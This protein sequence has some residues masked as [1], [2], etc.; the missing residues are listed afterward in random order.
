[1]RR[2]E[3]YIYQ[4]PDWPRFFWNTE[5]LLTLLTEVRNMQGRIVGQMSVLGFSLKDHANLEILTQDILNSTE[6]EGEVLDKNQVRSS[7]ARRLGL[8][9][10]GL[11]ASD[12]NVD[13]VVEMMIDAT[14][15]FDQPLT[16]GRIIGWHN[17]LFPSGYSGMLK[18]RVGKFRD[19][20]S[21]PMQV[22]SGPIGKEKVHYQAPPAAALEIEMAAFFDWFNKEQ[23]I[24]LV[25]KSA[26][27]HLWFVTLHPFDD[28]NGRIARALADMILA[29]SDGQSYRF[30]SMSSQI[31]AER[32]QYYEVLEK[33]QKSSLDVTCWLEWFLKCLLNAIKE[34]AKTLGLV[35]FKH[36][37]WLAN[38]AKLENERQRKMLN[39]LLDGFDGNLTSSKWAK[40]CKCSQDTALRDI[41]DLLEK[42]ILQKLP[43]GSR[44]TAYALKKGCPTGL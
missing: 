4:K 22:I 33:T 13:A 18:I 16:R 2:I 9:V 41:R 36:N 3:K 11:V 40:I 24:D 21:G 37:F 25:I 43:G 15:N 38:A 27:A 14:R 34:S 7:I 23:G 8:N 32:K 28:G 19:D 1:M 5:K 39:K 31:R 12:R 20:A 17:T 6:I 42:Q 10:S 35:V 29:R 30:Y 44:S 26:L